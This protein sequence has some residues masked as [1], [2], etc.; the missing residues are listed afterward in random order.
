MNE[1]EVWIL[2]AGGAGKDILQWT[3]DWISYK[4]YS[5]V[6]KGFIDD[7]YSGGIVRGS[8][9]QV[10]PIEKA[11]SI[12]VDYGKCFICALG[13]PEVKR[14]YMEEILLNKGEVVTIVHP[15]SYVAESAILDSGCVVCPQAVVAPNANV[16]IVTTIGI[17]ASVGHDAQIGSYCEISPGVRISGRSKIGNG[18]LI[19]SNAVI[20]PN[21]SIGNNARIS[22]GSVVVKD[23]GENETVIGNPARAI[24]KKN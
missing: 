3:F 11:G 4:E 13:E 8:S 14:R 2:G 22:A 12:P 7:K 5:Y 21:L 17:H 18:V 6:I 23:V 1:K 19:G 15:S 9:G 20:F 16:G 24:W 10:L